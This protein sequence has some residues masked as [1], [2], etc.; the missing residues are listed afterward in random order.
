MTCRLPA[1]CKA[2]K[3]VIAFA[4]LAMP[5]RFFD[6]L[7]SMG[8]T[9]L[10]KIAFGDHKPYT[11]ASAQ[12]LLALARRHQAPL[13]TTEKDRARLQ[14]YPA[15]SLRH[16]LFQRA[17]AI[18]IEITVKDTALWHTVLRTG[19]AHKGLARTG[20]APTSSVSG[21]VK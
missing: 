11:E 1:A 2:H 7:E 9:C 20:L 4:G 13:L 16:Q 21:G 14:G 10:E 5:Q 8:K 18:P 12:R 17:L 15:T 19:L 3:N 6:M